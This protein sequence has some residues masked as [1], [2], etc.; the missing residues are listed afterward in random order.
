MSANNDREWF[1]ANKERYLSALGEFEG[2]S[3]RLID[4]IAEF[5]PTVQG[6]KVKDCTYRIYRDT[7]FSSDKSPYKTHMGV[8]V[9]PGGKKT[10]LVGYYLH[11]EPCAGSDKYRYFMV[12]G[13][14]GL[15]TA[16]MN[17]IREDIV[18]EGDAFEKTLKSAKGF[19]F[20]SE[21]KYKRVP[22]GFDPASPYAEYLRHKDFQ[23]IKSLTE[24]Q[25]L[26]DG[27]VGFLAKEFHRTMDFKERLNRAIEFAREQN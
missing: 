23:L 16:E 12:T 17:S 4:A 21:E 14:Y 13:T 18:L 10:R 7:R 27:F 26:D 8:F 1:N 5:D 15:S 3:Q 20:E 9:S 6:L 19:S 22:N 24:E 11:L 25:V 2:F